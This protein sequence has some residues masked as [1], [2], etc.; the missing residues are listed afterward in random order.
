MASSAVSCNSAFRGIS[1]FVASQSGEPLL[2]A[3][4][5][6]LLYTI[7]SIILLFAC[8]SLVMV[9][10]KGEGWREKTAQ[11]KEEKEEQARMEADAKQDET[12][13]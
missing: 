8:L 9:A 7:W 1:G 12:G 11:K 2:T 6:G 4:G 10:W 5:N 13:A 3:I